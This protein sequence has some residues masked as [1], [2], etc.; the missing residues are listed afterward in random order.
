VIEN[1]VQALLT[2]RRDSLDDAGKNGIKV[3]G[4]LPGGYVPEELIHASG[5][6]PICLSNGGEAQVAREGLSVLPHVICPFARAQVGEALLGRDPFYKALDLV[7]VPS[8]CQ[9]LRIVGDVWEYYGGPEVF[10]LGVPYDPSDGFSLT[11]YKNRLADL[12][13]K[14]ERITGREVSDEAIRASITTYNRLRS[15]LKK[16]SL[17]RQN[18]GP[19]VS[20]FDFARL[21]HA[22]LYADPVKTVSTLES[23]YRDLT[24]GASAPSGGKRPRLLLA[25]PNLAHG[26]YDVLVMIDEVGGRVVVEDIFEGFRDYW[27]DEV[28]DGDPLEALAASYCLGRLPSV[29]MRSSSHRRIE[30]LLRLAQEFKVRGVVWYELLCCECYDQ[31]SYLVERKLREAGIPMI[32][33]ESDYGDL[34]VGAVRTRLEA[35]VELLQGGFVDA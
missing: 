27:Q 10:K 9:H 4:Y 20:A 35:F 1:Y 30:F 15:L 13:A 22:S 17:T 34:K 25:G 3:V 19:S 21:N 33:I 5:A 18:E 12:R 32:A 16:I 11:Y 23:V 24:C 6:I 8:T 7:V 31:E 14:L 28:D 2:D 29:F 26:D